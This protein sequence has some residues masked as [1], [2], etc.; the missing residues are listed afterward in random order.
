MPVP[1]NAVV[2]V[3][4][5]GVVQSALSHKDTQVILIDWDAIAEYYPGDAA[6]EIVDDFLGD[7]PFR[8]IFDL[9]DIGVLPY[10]E[11]EEK[12]EDEVFNG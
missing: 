11:E 2:I 5:G 3:V 12:E 9:D 10:E 1:N 8:P 7:A 6:D 4:S